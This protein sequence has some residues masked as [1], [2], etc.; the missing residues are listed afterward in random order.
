MSSN[1]I[2][3]NK[4]KPERSSPISSFISRT[5][6]PSGVSPC[7]TWPPGTSQVSGKGCPA[8][9]SSGTAGPL[10]VA[11]TN[12]MLAPL[13]FIRDYPQITQITQRYYRQVRHH[14]HPILTSDLRPPTSIFRLASCT[15]HLVSCI[16]PYE[17]YLRNISH[18]CDSEERS[19]PPSGGFR[20]VCG[21]APG[22]RAVSPM[23]S[24]SAGFRRATPSLFDPPFVS[25][26]RGTRKTPSRACSRP[27]PHGGLTP[28]PYLFPDPRRKGESDH[29]RSDRCL[30]RH[31]GHRHQTVH[32]RRRLLP[33][34]RRPGVGE[35][36]KAHGEEQNRK[37]SHARPA[38]R[39]R[40]GAKTPRS[41]ERDKR[42]ERD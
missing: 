13:R 30:R 10:S 12:R 33:G 32:P 27:A 2:T 22:A 23:R 34:C 31:P 21:W 25:T 19:F 39:Y 20:P 35:K 29:D 4:P 37:E 28:S 16:H 7:S 3:Q 26:P 17:R 6:H 18:R 41:G 42:D 40:R 5:M 15:L 38:L 8:F 11:F 24:S 14:R 1:S 36:S 9:G